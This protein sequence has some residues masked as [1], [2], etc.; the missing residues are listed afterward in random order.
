MEH[1][2]GSSAG[3]EHEGKPLHPSSPSHNHESSGAQQHGWDSNV[4]GFPNG[5]VNAHGIRR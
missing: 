4:F 3:W 1:H 5:I 2:K